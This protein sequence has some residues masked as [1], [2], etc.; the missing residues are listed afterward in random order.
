MP[1]SHWVFSWP[2]GEQPTCRQVD[3]LVEFFL[4]GMGLEG[5]QAIYGLHCD[6]RNYHVHIAVNR[7]H[8]ETLKVI[9]TN[10]G[11]DI[12]QAHKIRVMLEKMQGWSQLE[13][14]P[15]VVTEEGDIAQRITD[16]APKPSPKA[17]EFEKA[18][19]EKSAQR[20][21]QERGH[22][23]I[24]NAKSWD[25]LHNGLKNVGLRFEKKGSGAII[26]VGETAIKASSVDRSFSMGN[27]VKRLGEFVAGNYEAAMPGI[28]PESLNPAIAPDLQ[29]FQAATMELAKRKKENAEREQEERERLLAK[30]KLDRAVKLGNIARE[31]CRPILNIASYCLKI[32]QREERQAL[33]KKQT[34]NRA[35]FA[36]PKFNQWLLQRG[37]NLAA[38]QSAEIAGISRQAI[39]PLPQT[40]PAAQSPQ[41]KAFLEYAKAVD[42]DRYRVT[43]IKMDED[44]SRKVFILDKKDGQSMGFTP[45]E[46][47]RKMPEILKLQK[48]GENIYYTPLSEDKHHILIDDVSPE[49]VVRLQK[50]GYKPAAIIESS[51]HNFQCILTTPKFGGEFDRQI[52]NQLTA[53]LNRE[54]G[55]PKLSGAIHP[56]RAPGF[57]NFKPIHRQANGAY[58]LVML[59]FAVKQICKKALVEARKVEMAL[60]QRFLEREKNAPKFMPTSGLPVPQNAYF[61]HYENIRSHLTIEDFSRVDAMIALRMRANGHSPQAVLAAIRECAPAIR[62][63]TDKRRDW[64]KYAERTTN[65]AFGFA[66]DRDMERNA[67]YFET[68]QKIEQSP[69]RA[70]ARIGAR[71][72]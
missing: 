42:A 58:P 8:P 48:R 4:K 66:G 24:K 35:S 68:W 53:M 23:I 50:D 39:P 37:K 21:A 41:A 32:Q 19:G 29:I 43:A 17:V 6:T 9:R 47:V 56:H 11:F 20:I 7:V 18:T 40:S 38:S 1:V 65:Y 44:G 57:G 62:T 27:L 45:E 36:R 52:A 49:N 13:N 64:Q 61:A 63:G 2:E 22:E 3:E 34:E 71:I 60:K 51:P 26:W 46:L 25:E 28:E 12:R 16:T 30:Q 5:H 69:D 70:A 33:R 14:S 54:Y 59:R 55:D 10:N 72:R 15:Y 31:H 67:R